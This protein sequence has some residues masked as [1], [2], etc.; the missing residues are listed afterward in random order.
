MVAGALGLDAVSRWLPF[1]SFGGPGTIS[2]ASYVVVCVVGLAAAAVLVFHYAR[3]RT[4]A[5]RILL[6]ALAIFQGAALM[7]ASNGRAILDRLVA[8]SS[9]RL[10]NGEPT[11]SYD[12]TREPPPPMAG[13]GLI[14]QLHIPI[15][16]EGLPPGIL[17]AAESID[18]NV[19]APGESD[20]H[21]AAELAGATPVAISNG[22]A[23]LSAQSRAFLCAPAT[24]AA[25]SR[26]TAPHSGQSSHA[27]NA[28]VRQTRAHN[29]RRLVLHAGASPRLSDLLLA[30][31]DSGLHTGLESSASHPSGGDRQ[32]LH[33]PRRH[34]LHR[35]RRSVG[36]E[37][38]AG[39]HHTNSA[40]P[41][42]SGGPQH[43]R[44]LGGDARHP[45]LE[46][47]EIH[48][49]GRDSRLQWLEPAA[50]G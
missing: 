3:R 44:P 46:S 45:R 28:P 31:P 19:S 15:R 34:H 13:P 26:P 22:D 48:G 7:D 47:L 2:R 33:G 39:N 42:N 21:Q 24:A 12:P 43:H 49:P 23:W 29:R 38:M 32:L 9:S 8:A 20:Y 40:R 18:Y 41:G 25:F 35:S 36:S 4:A 1:R 30:G 50:L 6:V 11:I 14:D 5:T 10:P 16:I 27:P 37:R 17:V